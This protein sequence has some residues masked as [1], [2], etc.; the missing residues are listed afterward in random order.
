MVRFR[1]LLKST[2]NTLA[3]SS[4]LTE[5]TESAAREIEEID[6]GSRDVRSI[7]DELSRTINENGREQEKLAESGERVRKEMGTQTTAVE[8]SSAAVEEMAASILQ[9]TRSAQEKSKSV[10]AL[11][12]EASLTESTFDETIKSLTGLEKS[13]GEV[14]EVIAVIEEIA[15]R[16]NLLAMNAAIEA[17]HAGDSGKGFAVVADEIRKLAEETNENS[18]ISRDILT[19]ND[20]DIHAVVSASEES[21]IQ[22]RNIQKRTAE[23]REALEEIIR[24]MAEVSQGTTEINEV[25][26]GLQSI[27]HSVSESVDSMGAIITNTRSAF[28]SIQERAGGVSTVIG[29][30]ATKTERLREQ[31]LALRRIG[32]QNESGIR[33]LREKIDDLEK[34]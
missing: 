33:A 4:D 20:A 17:A 26:A 34:V 32:Q 13:S 25:I 2:Q 1:D 18:R 31:T 9:M 5:V 28:A 11:A 22:F 6:M 12:Q 3:I 7:L 8:R 16:T 15:S 10:E 19:K 29:T 21:Q 14:L 30:I 27:H 23:V 24:G